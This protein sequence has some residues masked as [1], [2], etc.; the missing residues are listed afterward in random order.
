MAKQMGGG[1]QCIFGSLCVLDMTRCTDT[2]RTFDVV[3][4]TSL[5]VLS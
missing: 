1:G 4:V 2:F 5:R 3:G